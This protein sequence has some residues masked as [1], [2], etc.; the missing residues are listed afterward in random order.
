MAVNMA[1]EI[2]AELL[3]TKIEKH[4]KIWRKQ[5]IYMMLWQQH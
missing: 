1:R 2:N 5:N 4:S 3:D